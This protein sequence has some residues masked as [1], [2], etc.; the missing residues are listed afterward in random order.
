MRSVV[1]SRTQTLV[2]LVAEADAQTDV[3]ANTYERRQ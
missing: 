3:S 1:S 2:V